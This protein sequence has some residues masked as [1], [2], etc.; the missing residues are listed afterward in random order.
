MPVGR[1]IFD[2][3]NPT[4]PIFLPCDP[5][6]DEEC[7]CQK[8]KTGLTIKDL[9]WQCSCGAIDAQLWNLR[10]SCPQCHKKDEGKKAFMDALRGAFKL[11]GF[12]PSERNDSLIE[13][14]V[15]RPGLMTLARLADDD[16]L[17]ISPQKP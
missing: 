17:S 10:E 5:G 2:S 15:L 4:I 8:C 12:E 7:T 14:A 13:K 11:N 3:I 16:S 9:C 6:A 1:M